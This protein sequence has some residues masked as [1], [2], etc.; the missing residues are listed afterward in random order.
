[1]NCRSAPT[2]SALFALTDLL[3]PHI[4]SRVVTVSSQLHRRGRLDPDDLNWQRRRYRSLQAYC[5][6][7]LANLLFTLELQRR[8]DRGR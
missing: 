2:T 1:M 4:T 3:L 6:S 8:L 5:D 7:K